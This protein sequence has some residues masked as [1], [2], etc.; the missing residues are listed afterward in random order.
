MSWCDFWYSYKNRKLHKILRSI[1]I[2]KRKFLG[3]EWKQKILI[4]KNC[5]EFHEFHNQLQLCQIPSLVTEKV[6]FAS[7]FIFFTEIPSN[8][9]KFVPNFSVIRHNFCIIPPKRTFYSFWCTDNWLSNS[10]NLLIMIM[11]FVIIFNY[12]TEKIWFQNFFQ[13][14]PNFHNGIEKSIMPTLSTFKRIILPK[15][16]NVWEGMV[17]SYI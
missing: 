11:V 10:H 3:W 13:S 2:T 14:H 1:P 6:I 5:D 15:L 7:F 16:E 4:K 12:K 17:V 8:S 9:T